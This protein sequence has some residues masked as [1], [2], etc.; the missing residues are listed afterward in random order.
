M[1]VLNRNE[2]VQFV[3]NT[4]APNSSFETIKPPISA[5]FIARLLWRHI[6]IMMR[7][8]FIIFICVLKIEGVGGKDFFIFRGNN[9]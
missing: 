2:F 1:I 5:K 8:S 9:G 7:G 6:K 4:L 3:S